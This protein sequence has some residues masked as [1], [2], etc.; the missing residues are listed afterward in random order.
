MRAPRLCS[1]S[2][3][4]VF[5]FSGVFCV[6]PCCAL[7]ES[8]GAPCSLATWGRLSACCAAV[9]APGSRTPP[10]HPR[11]PSRGGGAPP[12][13]LSPPPPSSLPTT[14]VPSP[15]PPPPASPLHLPPPLPSPTHPP[16]SSQGHVWPERAGPVRAG[17]RPVPQSAGLAQMPSGAWQQRPLQDGRKHAG[18]SRGV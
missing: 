14:P 18:D 2:A 17:A 6:F 3:L 10:P 9:R 1:L 13:P 5:P 15:S 12:V 16:P 8:G 11:F 4:G 7:A